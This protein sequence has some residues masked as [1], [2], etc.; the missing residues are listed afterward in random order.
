MKTKI[1]WICAI[2]IFVILSSCNQSNSNGNYLEQESPFKVVKIDKKSFKSIGDSYQFTF[3]GEVENKSTNIYDEVYTTMSIEFELENG[4][5]ITERD[6]NS[7]L[8]ANPGELEKAWKPNEVRK[9]DERGGIDS[10]FVPKRY[11]D[12]PIKRVV[13]VLSFSTEDIINKTKD[14][15]YYTLD[16]TNIWKDL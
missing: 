12:Y 8:W 11:K 14:D 4:N 7:G 1:K 2:S 6:Y 3:S 15:F 16:I 13:A 5:I 9:I 10:D